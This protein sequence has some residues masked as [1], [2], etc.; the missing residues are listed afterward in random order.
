MQIIGPLIVGF[1]IG[2]YGAFWLSLLITCIAFVAFVMNLKEIQPYS[3]RIQNKNR[4][5]KPIMNKG[6]DIIE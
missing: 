6:F 1:I 5:L 3:Y 2:V 4:A